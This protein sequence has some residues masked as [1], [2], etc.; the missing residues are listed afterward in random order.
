MQTGSG[1]SLL[2]FK[3]RGIGMMGY[4]SLGN[5]AQGAATDL[6]VRAYVFRDPQGHKV[7]FA[8]AEICFVTAAVKREVIRRLT[9]EHPDRELY[10]AN[11]LLSAQHTHSAPGGYSH[12][13]FYNV[14]V[15][16]FQPAVF[17]AIVEA[18]VDALLQ[19]DESLQAATLSLAT[20]LF[21]P[22][23]EVG[24]NRSLKSYRQ[25]PE[26]PPYTDTETH[27]AIDRTMPVLRAHSPT[28]DPLAMI[29]WFGVHATSIGN[30]N[31][32]INADNKGYAS[33]YFEQRLRQQRGTPVPA[34]FAQATAGDVSP[35][36]YGAGQP[37]P[38]GKFTDE[39]ESAR[40]NGRLQ[41]DLAWNTFHQPG[42]LHVDG[43]ID[44]AQIYVDFSQVE[45]DP[46]YTGGKT[47]C[48]TSG[49]AHGVAFFKGTTVDG[50]GV[51]PAVATLLS[52]VAKGLKAAELKR[53][54]R[55]TP[56]ERARILAKY[57][58]QG[59][60]QILFESGEK[61]FLGTRDISQLPIPNFLEPV[62][63]RL[64]NLHR[65]GAIQE[66]TWTPHILPVQIVVV[67]KLAIL[68]FPGEL[69]TIAGQRLRSSVQEILATRGVEQVVVTTYSNDYLGYVCT[70]EEYQMQAYEGGHTVFG[71]WSLAAFQTA[72]AQVARAL[73][74]P[75][76]ERCLDTTLQ[77]PVFSERE[78]ALRS[79]P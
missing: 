5:I 73:C 21:P 46:A 38:K 7:A 31:R 53:A 51:S 43:P 47:G 19:A 17:A 40:Y 61:T 29:S 23:Q 70:F 44:S 30:T 67:G 41:A 36:Y 28:G 57:E 3:Q 27:L 1:K 54:E 78:L 74:Q 11:V 4:G 72:F 2:R 39:F 20:G 26:A 64:K 34:I 37:I 10:D 69:T 48:R 16:G 32:L 63:G 18:F 56:E 42:A 77:P 66:H 15:P 55:A 35:N 59:P 13:V 60:K 24:Y 65:T 14:T 68:G 45:A 25:N 62:I 49:S 52:A 9:T 58:A 71:Q 8:N 22:E 76:A 75:L 79:A 50:P 33:L 12:Y 6:Y